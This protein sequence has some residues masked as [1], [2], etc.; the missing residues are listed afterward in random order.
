M[1]N[2]IVEWCSFGN[3]CNPD[4]NEDSTMKPFYDWYMYIRC[5]CE[6]CDDVYVLNG[7]PYYFFF[8]NDTLK[9]R[10]DTN[11]TTYN[12]RNVRSYIRH[13]DFEPH[14]EDYAKITN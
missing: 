8:I 10:L 14:L 7:M 13:K 4:W 1:K 12:V 11:P 9:L 3:E 5:V 6:V 2:N